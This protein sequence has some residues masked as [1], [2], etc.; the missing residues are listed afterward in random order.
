MNLR[1]IMQKNFSSLFK[2]IEINKKL[3]CYKKH[4]SSYLLKNYLKVISIK[5]LFLCKKIDKLLMLNKKQLKNSVK[6]TGDFF[7]SSYSYSASNHKYSKT[8]YFNLTFS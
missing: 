3:F 7:F 5:L 8:E 1:K 6:T 2:T 4:I